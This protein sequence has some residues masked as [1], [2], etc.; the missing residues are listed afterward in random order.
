L[1]FGWFVVS[2]KKRESFNF[3]FPAFFHS[4]KRELGANEISYTT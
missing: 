3:Y 1:Y 4:I 2:E